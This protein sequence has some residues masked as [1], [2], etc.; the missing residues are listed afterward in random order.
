MT[1]PAKTKAA[2]E[3]LRRVKALPCGL[4]GAAAPSDAHHPRCFAGMGEKCSDWLV[5]P[6]CRLCHSNFHDGD[7]ALWRIYKKD[8][9]A[10]LAETI[11]VLL[12][13]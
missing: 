7:R 1:R 5:I 9:P 2:V 12:N 6:L 4:C 11:K 8:E 13:G 3:H 10:I